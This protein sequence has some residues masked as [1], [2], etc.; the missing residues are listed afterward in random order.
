MTELLLLL[1]ASLPFLVFSVFLLGLFVGSFLNVVICRLPVMMESEWRSQCRDLLH[2]D[3]AVE[4]PPRF[5]LVQPRS[6]CPQCKT[7]IRARDNVPVLS[8]LLLRGKCRSCQKPIPARYPIVEAVS[9]LLCAVVAWYFGYSPVTLCAL[10]LTWS[11]L[12]LTLIDYDHQLLPDI[13]T[14]PMLWLGLFA[15]IW[16]TVPGVDLQTA[17]IGAIAGYLS[18]WTVF[19]L[20]R[21][22]TGKEGMGYGDFKLLAMLGAWLGWQ[23]IPVIVLLS[24]LVGAMVGISLV[25]FQGRDR[26]RPIP[27]GPY[28]AAAGWISL[29]WGNTI[30]E[31]YLRFSMGPL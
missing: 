1:E 26:N 21:L 31:T 13:I 17:V 28:L 25:I 11:L 16:E 4:T 5:N 29:L 15:A 7:P 10:A 9:A 23:M 14:L 24:S 27:F 19:H 18:L 20:F 6:R 2:P 22:V 12:A 3:Q 30:I 8:W